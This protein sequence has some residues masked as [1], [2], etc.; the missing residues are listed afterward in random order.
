M[1][2]INDNIW[3]IQS[4]EKFVTKAEYYLKAL[5]VA[6]GVFKEEGNNNEK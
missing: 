2:Y 1:E 5:L 3:A 4:I 6:E